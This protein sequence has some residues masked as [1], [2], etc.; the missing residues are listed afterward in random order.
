VGNIAQ[1]G[2][3]TFNV[4]GNNIY[5]FDGFT[6]SSS[7]STESQEVSG[8]KPST[9][10]KGD[11]L[12]TLG[13]NISLNN[14]FG[15]DVRAEIEEWEKIKNSHQAQMFI[16][17]GKSISKNKYML[18]SVDILETVIDNKGNMRSAKLTLSFEEYVRQA[19]GS[20]TGTSDP[21]GTYKYSPGFQK[22]VDTISSVDGKKVAN[23]VTGLLTG[24]VQKDLLKRTSTN[25]LAA[26]SKGINDNKI[27][28]DKRLQDTANLIN[29]PDIAS[30]FNI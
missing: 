1:F 15:I 17:G 7:V 12:D 11:N 25:V 3:K 29:L 10:I 21:N 24:N 4:S 5:T 14:R 9:H 19:S 28:L 22:V 13:F 23:V 8:G 2:N 30:K 26:L 16:L 6:K 20:G 27:I 18:K